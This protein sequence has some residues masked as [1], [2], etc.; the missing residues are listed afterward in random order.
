MRKI[1]VV[2]IISCQHPDHWYVDDIGCTVEVIDYGRDCVV[3]EDYTYG[4][5]G[6]W[7]H[8][9]KDDT[10]MLSTKVASLDS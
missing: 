2:R 3:Y 5:G 8:I 9:E 10:E 7:R 6:P 1:I 4:Y